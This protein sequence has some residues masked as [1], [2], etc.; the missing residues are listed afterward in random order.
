M[1]VRPA[2]ANSGFSFKRVDLD[3]V[4]NVIAARFDRVRPSQL[5]TRIENESG[6]S[7]ST[8]E[9]VLAGLVACG[10]HNADIELDGPEVPI[11]DGSSLQFARAMLDA[12]VVELNRPVKVVKVKRMVE[13][14]GDDCAASLEPSDRFEMEFLI[15]FP[16]PIGVQTRAEDLANGAIVK[17]LVASRTFCLMSQLD[18][19]MKQG[20]GQGGEINR[21]VL[22][23]DDT[24]NCFLDESRHADECVRHKMLDAVGDLALAG[25]PIVGKFKGY[26]S[27]HALTNAL[28]RKLFS[29]PKSFEIVE[30]DVKTASELPGAGA[31]SSDIP[32]C[33]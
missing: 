20:L 22:V 31:E 19:L 26:K 2:D 32:D 27:G 5:C 33:C 25:Y 21:N 17:R 15:S 29:D 24:R 13:V 14:I 16:A 30:A 12:G 1:V 11:M 10:I 8:V 28:L 3:C 23:A 7:V 6:V 4:D 9:H 18:W